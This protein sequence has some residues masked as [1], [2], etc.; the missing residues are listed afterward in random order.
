MTQ[1]ESLEKHIGKMVK[2]GKVSVLRDESTI[3]QLRGKLPKGV[4]NFYLSKLRILITLKYKFNRFLETLL[5]KCMP[6]K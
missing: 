4:V 5:T 2:L 3:M 1:N 6:A